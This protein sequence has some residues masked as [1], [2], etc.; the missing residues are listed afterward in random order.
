VFPSSLLID[1]SLRKT[2]SGFSVGVRLCWYRAL[3]LSSI[4]ILTLTVDGNPVASENI[5]FVLDGS[6]HRLDDLPALYKESWFVTDPAELRVSLPDEFA[7][8]E[9]HDLD[10]TLGLR[11]PY[12]LIEGTDDTL[13]EV[14]HCQKRL[15][16]N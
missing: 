8:G 6:T 10:L 12:V 5:T 16:V 3:P 13:T 1:G 9:K 4:K 14:D 2:D 11:I 15:L 7:A